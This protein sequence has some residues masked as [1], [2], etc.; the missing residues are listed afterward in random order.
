MARILVLGSGAAL[1]AKGR[2]NTSLALLKNARTILLDCAQPASELL[3]HHGIDVTS[4]DTIV[5][6]H[7]H[8]DHVTGLGQ[9]VHM[10]HHYIDNVAPRALLDRQLPIF[11][12]RLRHPA[13]IDWND[14]NP[15]INIYVPAGVEDVIRQ[16]LAAVFQRPEVYT[17]FEVNVL[18]FESG[19][20]HKDNDFSLTAFSNEHLR[21]YYPELRDTDAVLS[22]YSIMVE[23]GER[24]CLYSSDLA[25]LSEIDRLV[26]HADT[27]FIEG[28]HFGPSEIIGFARRHQLDRVFIH[29]ILATWEEEID[30]MKSELTQ[31][32]ITPTFDGL[33]VEF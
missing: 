6:T 11:K 30:R 25:S 12:N 8:A 20:F 13:P 7:M 3:Y 18:P 26:E 2:F 29:H 32:N 5:V 27:V 4:V 21:Q 28:A 15:W 24:K 33:E 23:C 19:E 1:A 22:S 16:Y 10:K 9:L 17:N 14:V 31:N